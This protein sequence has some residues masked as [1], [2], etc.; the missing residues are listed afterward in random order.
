MNTHFN[1]SGSAINAVLNHR[2]GSPGRGWVAALVGLVTLALLGGQGTASGRIAYISDETGD[3]QI[4]VMNADGSSVT[5]LTHS[6][7]TDAEPEWSY[8]GSRIVFT[9]DQDGDSD[10]Y[11]MN[12]DGSNLRN[13]T[14][15]EMEEGGPV[16]SHA[17]AGAGRPCA[18][19]IAFHANW[20]GNW[21]L[22]MMK[23]DGSDVTRL[24]DNPDIDWWP[25][26]SPDG[27]KLAFM[28]DRDN[29]Y[30]DIYVLNLVN[31][32]IE[33]LTDSPGVEDIWPT[34]SPDGSL[35]AFVSDVTGFYQLFVIGANCAPSC[36]SSLRQVTPPALAHD[37]DPAWSPDGRWLAFSSTR[38]PSEPNLGLQWDFEIF[39]IHV[40][41]GGLTQLTDNDYVDDFTPAWTK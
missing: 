4:Y 27:K 20:D 16:F 22:Y 5:R 36:Q 12:A 31:G 9:S 41:G 23:D 34:W 7:G 21:D 28:S 35:I 11:L 39:I 6:T 1:P 25:S 2:S 15:T 17:C 26:W 19:W 30:F 8:D 3:Y 37:L 10:I 24:T 32:A 40:D 13:L 14:N 38:D 29:G 18:E 33:N